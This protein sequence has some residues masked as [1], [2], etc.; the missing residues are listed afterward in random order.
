MAMM[1]KFKTICFKC[2]KRLDSGQ[3]FL[4][5]INGKWLGHCLDCYKKNKVKKT[6]IEEVSTTYK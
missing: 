5:R 1:I 4:T 2:G 6:K 3:G